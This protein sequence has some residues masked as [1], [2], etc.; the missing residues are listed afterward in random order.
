MAKLRAVKP[1]VKEIG[2]SKMILYGREKVG[3][4]T[5]ALT[6]PAVYYIDTEGGAVR[7]QYQE[8][9]A[10]SGGAYFGQAQGSLDFK[11]VLEEIETLATEKHGF[12]T[13]VIDSFSKLYNT[14]RAIAEED[15]KIGAAFGADKREANRPARQLIRWLDKLDMNVILIC[16][17]LDQWGGQ[18]KDRQIVGTTF[19]GYDK[20]AYELDLLVEAVKVGHDRKFMV[21]ASR[22][23]Q[24][25]EGLIADLN[26]SVF[27]E[28]F[29]IAKLTKDQTVYVKATAEQV[30]QMRE[31]IKRENLS[32]EKISKWLQTMNCESTFEI[33]SERAQAFIEVHS[34]KENK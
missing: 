7:E 24:M 6:F 19:D 9:L 15:T 12:K 14:A 25:P 16:H 32:E 26:F 31:I 21:K 5:F 34:K 1:E 28:A 27:A 30:G 33:P 13:L 2:R 17:K 20:L 3:K 4:T 11:T 22:I 18:G 8:Q 23:M 29:G 10:K